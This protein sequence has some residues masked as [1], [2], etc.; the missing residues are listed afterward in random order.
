ME[1]KVV[2]K[3]RGILDFIETVGNKLPHPATIFIFLC[4]GIIILSAVL[5]NM[6]VSVT[7][8]GLDRTTNE[9]K[10]MTATV[11][12]LLSSDGI[13]YMFKS[14]IT[15][16]T[17][18][19]A[20][21]TVLVAMLGVGVAEG[22]GLIGTSLKSLVS[23]TPKSLITVVVVFAGVM[24]S[25]ASDAGYVVLIPL[26]AVVFLSFG[27]HPLAGI[28]AA[29]AGVSGGFSANLLPGPTDAL[30][31]GITT[32]GAKII[33]PEYAVSVTANWFFLIVSTFLITIIGTIITEKVVE[34][35][36]GEYKPKTSEKSINM[37]GLTLK[38][39]RGLKF[40]GIFLL[41][42]LII[43]VA[44]VLP[45]SGILR[46]PETK[47]ILKS[48]FMDSI[49]VTIAFLFL[50]SGIGYGIGVGTIK[51]DKD[52]INQMGKTMSTMGGYIVLVFFASQFVAFFSHS[53]LG[54]VIAVK[55]S[56]FLK[57]TGISGIPLLIGFVIV[58]AFINLFMGSASAKWAI[59][60]PVFVPMLL[61]MGISPEFT[62]M[63]YRIGD[64]TTNII[65]PLMTYFALIVSFSEKYDKESGIGTM[66]STMVPYSLALLVGWT[67]LL[68]IWYAV[69]LP[70]GIY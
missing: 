38:E 21:G 1:N 36:L 48:P 69:G 28:A 68:I 16:F 50:I 26:G 8:T 22:T 6:G 2:K 25:I 64:S 54:T 66:I 33:N 32:E 30:L 31:A 47:E 45:E 58:T 46:N 65:S 12:S 53:N 34:P 39:K 13:R 37:I 43:I 14:L 15:N 11:T 52:V 51:N 63:A 42:G 18:F 44:L 3:R 19:A 23:K 55:G 62:Q 27:R 17:S 57:S 41:I 60:A 10:E 59:M 9:I 67:T 7:Y 70:L 5:S 56:E 20:L 29:F 24:S 4:M 49:V 40:A 35:R 61:R